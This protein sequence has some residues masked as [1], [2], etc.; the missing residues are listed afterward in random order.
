MAGSRRW[1][2]ESHA[3]GRLERRRRGSQRDLSAGISL[4]L[5]S[6]GMIVLGQ[7]ACAMLGCRDRL[8]RH[9]RREAG[10]TLTE[11]MVVLVIFGIMTAIALPAFIRFKRSLA[12]NNHVPLIAT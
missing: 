1:A 2:A 12:M 4:A 6:V 10:F 3:M 7:E 11:I 8:E 5:P 9:R